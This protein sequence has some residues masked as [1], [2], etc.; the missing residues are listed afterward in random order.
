MGADEVAAAMWGT[1]WRRASQTAVNLHQNF[2]K[3]HNFIF[4]KGNPLNMLIVGEVLE[5]I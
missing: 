5:Q 1:H 3:W 4:G 2:Q